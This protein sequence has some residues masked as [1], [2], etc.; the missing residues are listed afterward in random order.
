MNLRRLQRAGLFAATLAFTIFSVAT[1][2]SSIS[3]AAGKRCTIKGTNGPDKLVGTK[4]RD[5]ICGFGGNDR[6]WGR[7]GDD[8]IRGGR[9]KDVIRAGRGNDR[10]LGQPDNDRLYAGP[11]NDVLDG[12]QGKDFYV[13]GPGNNKC[14]DTATDMVTAGCDDTAP[15]LRELSL[16]PAQ[17]DTSEAPATVTVTLRLTDDLAGVRGKPSLE[18]DYDNTYQRRFVEFQRVSGDALDGVYQ[19]TL[20]L[21]RFSPE[22]AWN[23][24]LSVVDNQ[25]NSLSAGP[26]ALKKAGF[27]ASIQQ[28]GPGDQGGPEFKSFQLDKS[29]LDTSST[30]QTVNFQARVTDVLAGTGTDDSYR[31][32]EVILVNRDNQ[33]EQIQANNMTRISGDEHDG[34]YQG[35]ITFP[36]N[37]PTRTWEIRLGAIDYAG[38]MTLVSASQLA[39]LGFPSQITVTG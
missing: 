22:G 7:S 24:Y 37:S 11:G 9:G 3:D 15:V 14:Y 35:S 27:P 28:V 20:T 34:V 12:G 16:S 19:G 31:P 25:D 17:V 38:N 18:A 13:T 30:D 32:V 21:P 1:L 33:G 4:G 2:G 29:S 23:L 10:L 5:V 36:V 26:K 6:I 8:I 39:A